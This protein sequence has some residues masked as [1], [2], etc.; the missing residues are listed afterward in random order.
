MASLRK[1]VL[2]DRDI[3]FEGKKF[4][5]L[6]F[7]KWLALAQKK[8]AWNS[9]CRFLYKPS[10]DNITKIV[11]HKFDLLFEGQQ[12]ETLISRKRRELAQ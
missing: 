4:E 12:F 1:I 11:L 10:K 5:T 9:Y 2:R 6:I 3:L 7:P 8:N